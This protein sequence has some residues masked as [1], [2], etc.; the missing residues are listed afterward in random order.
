MTTKTICDDYGTPLALGDI[1]YDEG[2]V[3][4]W[5]SRFHYVEDCG[6]GP[7]IRD[8]AAHNVHAAIGKLRR[9]GA[10]NDPHV[11]ERLIGAGT[12]KTAKEIEDDVW[13]L[14]RHER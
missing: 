9:L 2:D 14:M 3:Q 7:E 4:D 8:F 5:H 13:E 12:Y 10:W 6:C 11:V 1:L